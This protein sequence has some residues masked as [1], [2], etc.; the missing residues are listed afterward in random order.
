MVNIGEGEEVVAA[1][2]ESAGLPFPIPIDRDGKVAKLY[3]VY[4]IPTA[5]LIDQQGRI[6]FGSH[7]YHNWESEKMYW[8]LDTLLNKDK[9]KPAVT[10]AVETYLWK[11]TVQGK[12][13][14][15]SPL[16]NNTS[17]LSRSRRSAGREPRSYTLF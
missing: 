14:V 12:L 2:V 3:Q 17:S 7:G 6:L 11:I 16:L 8:L 13:L 9:S 15:F 10:G 4:G 1:F 5:F